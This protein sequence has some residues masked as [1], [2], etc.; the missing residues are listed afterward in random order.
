MSDSDT[1]VELAKL[2]AS[3]HD[4]RRQYEW[5]VSFGFW[6]LLVGAFIKAETISK[7]SDSLSIFITGGCVVFLYAFIWLRGVWIANK[8]DKVLC[9]HFREQSTSK[10]INSSYTIV[11]P[12]GMLTKNNKEYWIGILTDWAMLFHL[13][14]TA[15]LVFL[16]CIQVWKGF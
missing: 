11:Q 13:L 6:A 15:I 1:L 7:I 9:E 10:L 16:V 12:P 2:A 14:V 8:N 3:R 4:Q 5:R